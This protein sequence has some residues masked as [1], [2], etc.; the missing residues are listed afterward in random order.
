[1]KQTLKSQACQRS[2][3]AFQTVSLGRISTFSRDA[4]NISR[5]KNCF[6]SQ[7]DGRQEN[8]SHLLIV[9]LRFQLKMYGLALSL[10]L[11][12]WLHSKWHTAIPKHL[13]Y[14]P[15]TKIYSNRV[16]LNMCHRLWRDLSSIW[17]LFQGYYFKETEHMLQFWHV[18]F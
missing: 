15:V 12:I 1:M 14:S 4:Q 13:V 11:F 16:N 2:T 5:N 8:Q 17:I 18:C 6:Q 10:V 7:L 3:V 9:T